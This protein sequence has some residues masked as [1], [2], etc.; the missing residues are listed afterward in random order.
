MIS[1]NNNT[2]DDQYL[3]KYENQPFTPI[4]IMGIQRSGTSI[5]Y[6]ILNETHNFNIVT[7]YHLIQYPELIH[8]H[9]NN[10]EHHA[11]EHLTKILTQHSQQDRGIDRLKV[12]P[13]FPEEYGFL[14][15]QKTQTSTT[16]N[17]N[18]PLL[19]SLCQKIQYTAHNKKPLLLKNPFDFS[20]FLLIHKNLPNAKFIFIHR[21]PLKTLNSQIKATRTLLQQ[22]SAYMALLSP[23][24]D[25][26]FDK[27]IT[28]SY[29]RF[30][31]S[32]KTPLRL[33][34][35]IKNLQ[36]HTSKLIQD[37]T[38]IPKETYYSTTYEDLCNQPKQCID[39]IMDFLKTDIQTQPNYIN[40]I[41]PRKTNWLQEI[42][43]N[44]EKI[45]QKFKEYLDFCG[46]DIETLMQLK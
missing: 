6:K 1:E 5:L 38:Q 31:Y 26:L 40:L 25:K 12:T 21:N 46:Y 2:P 33:H 15:T 32:D 29:Y 35:A 22:K 19:R 9:I 23:E 10:K 44:K 7:A 18:I 3:T 14:L 13:D 45:L 30:L 4:F 20:N 11:K 43:K 37:I 24:Y 39:S 17:E 34:N 42:S 8:N 27:K 36:S 28:L 41:A 16:T